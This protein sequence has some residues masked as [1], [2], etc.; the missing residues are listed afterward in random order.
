[1]K[2]STKIRS[3]FFISSKVNKLSYMSFNTV[4]GLGASRPKF[5]ES[6]ILLGARRYKSSNQ[7]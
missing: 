6:P 4:V 7:D 2:T 5:P 3:A 1:M